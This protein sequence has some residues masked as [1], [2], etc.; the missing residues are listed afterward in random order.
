[1]RNDGSRPRSQA[2]RMHSWMKN[3]N[4]PGP[5]TGCCSSRLCHLKCGCW[6]AAYSSPGSQLASSA[7]LHE[8]SPSSAVFFLCSLRWFFL[9]GS[10][11]MAGS[12]RHAIANGA[13]GRAAIK[14]ERTAVRGKAVLRPSVKSW[15]RRQSHAS[16]WVHFIPAI[17][18]RTIFTNAARPD[19][20]AFMS[21][22]F[23]TARSFASH[24]R[25]PDGSL[26]DSPSVLL[27]LTL[28]PR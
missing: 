13:A 15:M 1:M 22:N 9:L 26:I 12:D 5:G 8:A 11:G 4:P 6:D 28:A 21:T 19:S 24:S 3:Q 14:P 16:V 20:I 18:C 25:S 7:K 2:G 23:T 27:S 17:H 10:K